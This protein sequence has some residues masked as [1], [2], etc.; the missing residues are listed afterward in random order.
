MSKKLLWVLSV[1]MGAAMVALILMQVYWISNAIE[2]KEKQ[3]EQQINRL[4]SKISYDV[5]RSEAMSHIYNEFKPADTL[6]YSNNQKFFDTIISANNPRMSYRLEVLVNI[7]ILRLIHITRTIMNNNIASAVSLS[8]ILCR[9]C[10]LLIET[11][12]SALLPINLR[13]L[14]IPFSRTET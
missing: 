11:L 2:V 8:I 12:A 5:E 3:F 7:Q 14:L 1:F 9:T 10:L 6:L 4:L 13:K